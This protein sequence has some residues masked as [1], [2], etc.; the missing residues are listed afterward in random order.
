[1]LALA[2]HLGGAD[3]WDEHRLGYGVVT[4]VASLQHSASRLEVVAFVAKC[5][6]GERPLQFFR[7]FS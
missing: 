1:V 2:D 3:W 6:L 4:T 7:G 5:L